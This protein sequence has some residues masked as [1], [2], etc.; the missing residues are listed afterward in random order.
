MPQF[1]IVLLNDCIESEDVENYSDGLDWVVVSEMH[2][3]LH[4][5]LLNLTFFEEGILL[6]HEI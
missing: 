6:F 3:R 1:F 4:D 2:M 5:L